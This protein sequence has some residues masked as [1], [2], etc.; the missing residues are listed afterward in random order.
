MNPKIW[1]PPMWISLHSI[2]LNYP[3][4]PTTCQQ[5]MIKEFFWNLQFVLP[6][7]M[8][9]QHY[10][11]MIRTH[12]PIVTDRKSLVYWLIDRH[13]DVNR[14]LGKREYTYD[15]VIKKYENLYNIQSTD[16]TP[17]AILELSNDNMGISCE[18]PEAIQVNSQQNS[19][20]FAGIASKIILFL[21]L[22][23]ILMWLMKKK[24]K[25]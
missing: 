12:P 8:C 17:N 4:K 13:N 16:K 1:G 14:R 23:G 25:K 15:E 3:D 10:S 11:E 19:I 5:N 6:C 22:T 18:N 2:T 20:Q 7:E 24:G 21:A 9:R